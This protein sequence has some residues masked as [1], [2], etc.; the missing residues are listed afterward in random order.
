VH[1]IAAEIEQTINYNKK[2]KF[3][4]SKKTIKK[5]QR[6]FATGDYESLTRAHAHCAAF[7]R[8]FLALFYFIFHL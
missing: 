5:F 7:L 1:D 6:V 3:F 4:L 2:H 8:L